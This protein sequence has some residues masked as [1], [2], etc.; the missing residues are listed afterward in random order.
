MPADNLDPRHIRNILE[1]AADGI[2][3]FDAEGR[4]RFFNRAAETIFRATRDHALGQHISQ[5]IPEAFHDEQ[6]KHVHAAFPQAHARGREL[7]HETLGLRKDNTRV[8]LELDISEVQ[9][10]GTITYTAIVRDVTQQ[11]RMASL[12]GAL[13]Q[14]AEAATELEDLDSLYPR[15]HQIVSTI[16]DTTNFYIALREEGE[17]TYSFAYRVDQSDVV[18]GR[19]PIALPGSLTDYV[20]RKGK[21]VRLDGALYKQLVDK[22]EIH[23][24][25]KP[26]VSWLGTPLIAHGEN[27]GVMTVQSYSPESHYTDEDEKF[28]EFVSSEV[29]RAI[30]HRRSQQTQRLYTAAV[31]S[32]RDRIQ[33]QAESLA[34]Q[35]HDLEEARDSAQAATRAKSD[36]LANMSH[37]IRTPMNGIIGMAG[38]L[39]ETGLTGEQKEYAEI[40]RRSAD[41]LLTII[42]D[43]LDFSK[44]EARTLEL[45]SV[46]FDPR[47]IA[48][49]VADLLGPRT[50][51]KGLDLLLDIANDVPT[52]VHGDPG[53]LRQILLNLAGNAVKFTNQGYVLLRL[54]RCN[55]TGTTAT[56][57]FEIIDSGIG[58]PEDR[59]DRLFKSF[60]QVDTS[61]TRQFGGTGLGLAI[62][63]QLVEAMGGTIAVE[64]TI[65]KGSRFLFDLAF[66]AIAA[67]D[68]Q[69][70]ATRP[71]EARRVL[72]ASASEMASEIL[73]TT[74]LQWGLDVRTAHDER[75]ALHI[76]EEHASN[77]K[78]IEVAL[79]DDRPGALPAGELA[80]RIHG[81]TEL[82]ATHVVLITSPGRRPPA[83][84]LLDWGVSAL[85]SKPVK[86]SSLHSALATVL[87]IHT[88]DY[89]PG[90]AQRV[91]RRHRLRPAW[92]KKIAILIVEDN[93]VSARVL[94]RILEQ[95]GYATHTVPTGHQAVQAAQQQQY[96]AILMDIQLPDIDG[97][98]VARRIRAAEAD[99]RRTPIIANTARAT[100]EDRNRCFEAGMDDFLPKP[101]EAE[102]LLEALEK[103]LPPDAVDYV[104]T[105]DI[106]TTV[107][108]SPEL[109]SIRTLAADDPGFEQELVQLFLQT[110]SKDLDAASVAIDQARFD[111]ARAALLALAGSAECL[112]S[113]TLSSA[114]R[115]AARVVGRASSVVVEREFDH[116]HD[117]FRRLT[118]QLEAIA[119]ISDSSHVTERT[120]T[121]AADQ[122]A[123]WRGRVLVAEDD[124]VSRHLLQRYLE[125][126]GC[127]VL[128]AANGREAYEILRKDPAIA[129]LVTDWMMPEMDGLEL[130]RRARSLQRQEYL[131]TIMLTARADR[132]DFLEGMK[133]GADSFLAKP[134]DASELL[135]HLN[136]G[137]RIADL[138]RQL[139]EK[140]AEITAAHERIKDDLRLAARIQTSRLP[141]EKPRFPRAAFDWIFDSCEA[142]AGDMFNIIPLDERRVAVYVLDVS[143]HGVQAA[144]LSVTLSRVFSLGKDGTEFLRHQEGPH[145]GRIKKPS[146]IAAELNRR[147][148]MNIEISQFFTVVYGI[149]DMQ[150][151][152][153]TYTS[154]G[155][156]APIITSSGAASVHQGHIGPAIGILEDAKYHDNVI[157]LHRGDQV[158][159]MTDGIEETT[160]AKDNEFGIQRIIRSL[161]RGAARGISGAIRELREDVRN[162]SK[163]TPQ[164]DDITLIG[165]EIL[166]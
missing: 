125:R 49:E 43:I 70:H 98:E 28:M 78:P 4:I 60:S 115:E 132:S 140:L 160:D 82:A 55:T 26:A 57:R 151:R 59:R 3:V 44:V 1:T 128:L 29:A 13:L 65:G 163:G 116:V 121:P 41:S 109:S 67:S 76:I 149:L 14:I 6:G 157:Q 90:Q 53:R 46:E 58:I 155:H 63:Q 31:E 139:A 156:P 107:S 135:A 73:S 8:A 146:E 154:A 42:N 123:A 61:T 23:A 30:Q 11:K 9:L 100:G 5:F 21:P 130:V 85:L 80:R 45:E 129:F 103:H 120:P 74:M 143:G 99:T 66:E 134:F 7:A 18:Y 127:H 68:E 69:Q 117:E 77:G 110:A 161:E 112:G 148:P 164:A 75:T 95:A 106:A 81:D 91:R 142:V 153:F 62:S 2:L 136:V 12:Q 56:I 51:Q 40:I 48:E 35:A 111:E 39:L 87:R 37:E 34:R 133:A 158:A 102:R 22:G 92:R 150:K 114:A 101:L 86:P 71:F 72:I 27:I 126:W 25:G 159:L 83:G 24:Y 54:T 88:T 166:A 104:A 20:W 16:I 97:I 52:R 50:E 15:I 38:L 64:S 162:F 118:V 89:M 79:L 94:A 36:F 113:V 17:A 122:T 138:E 152:T 144:F 108:T 145:A 165:F 137:G 93:P 141:R 32:A 84:F 131:Y 124:P 47:A 119:P 10:D 19:E 105:E 33:S 96:A 147:F